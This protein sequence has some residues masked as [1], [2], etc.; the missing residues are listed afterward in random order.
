MKPAKDGFAYLNIP[1][2][3]RNKYV[4]KYDAIMDEIVKVETDY[5]PMKLVDRLSAPAN[6]QE[7]ANRPA[8]L[9]KLQV[10]IDKARK[11]RSAE[12]EKQ[13]YWESHPE[14]YI[15]HLEE[16]KR[17]KEAEKAKALA[18]EQRKAEA[19]KARA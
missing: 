8:T 19:R 18:E 14:E 3:L 5:K 11:T 4:A 16:E 15:A 6:Q 10:E 13:K 9:A 1:E 7:A 2:H 12:Y 17:K